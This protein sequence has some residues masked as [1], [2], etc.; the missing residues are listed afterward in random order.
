MAGC[1]GNAGLCV[2]ATAVCTNNYTAMSARNTICDLFTMT[3]T[4]AK[5][6]GVVVA[7][8]KTCSPLGRYDGS[9]AHPKTMGVRVAT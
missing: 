6:V 1:P 3:S 5:K 8:S 9:R 4:Q 7:S 2:P